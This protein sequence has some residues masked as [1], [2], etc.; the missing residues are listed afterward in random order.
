MAVLTVSL[1]ALGARLVGEKED[2]QFWIST[3]S[4]T[5]GHLII[6]FFLTLLVL[7]VDWG[8]HA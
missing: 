7:T 3:I 8:H 6:V 2:E 5:V 1:F 4:G